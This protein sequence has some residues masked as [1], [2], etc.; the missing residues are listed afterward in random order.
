MSG[1]DR[2]GPKRRG[3][4][5]DPPRSLLA[6]KQVGFYGGSRDSEPAF[7]SEATR[8]VYFSELW[9]CHMSLKIC[10][11][12][13]FRRLG[14]SSKQNV[15]RKHGVSVLALNVHLPKSNQHLPTSVSVHM[16]STKNEDLPGGTTGVD[17]RL[18]PHGSRCRCCSRTP[19]VLG[20]PGDGD[21]DGGRN[22]GR[23]RSL[24]LVTGVQFDSMDR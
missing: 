14:L 20:T 6:S 23:R 11:Q 21:G 4:S 8:Y 2:V 18:W 3:L 15:M 22:G 9:R 10:A 12:M 17:R 16:A 19:V 24:V 1:I 13:K 7:H 5:L